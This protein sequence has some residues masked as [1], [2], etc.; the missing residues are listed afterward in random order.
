MPPH[1]QLMRLENP[2]VLTQWL[3]QLGSQGCVAVTKA[4][5]NSK[6]SPF[7]GHLFH[8]LSPQP[9]TPPP[10]PHSQLMALLPISPRKIE[11]IRKEF[12]QA[13]T[14][15]STHLLASVP[16]YSS[17]TSVAADEPSV[18]PTKASHSMSLRY[19]PPLP[20][21]DI[22]LHLPV[23]LH[24]FIHLSPLGSPNNTHTQTHV[25]IDRVFPLSF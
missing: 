16:K 15:T 3:T 25:Y 13:P 8:T 2:H 18:L 23:Y 14:N 6:S 5:S 1:R 19:Y 12:P 21:K 11:A 20:L 7:L 4:F 24:C 10:R 22:Q 17:L 9:S